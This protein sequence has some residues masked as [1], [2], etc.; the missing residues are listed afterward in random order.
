[1]SDSRLAFVGGEENSLC[2]RGMGFDVYVA[3][4]AEEA[5]EFLPILRRSNYALIFTEWKFYSLVKEQFEDQRSEALPVILG[6]PTRKEEIGKGSEF[7]RELVR[8]A[9]GSDITL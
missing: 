2:F 3:Y 7:I 4:S 5:K 9:A 1:M 6:I 8:V